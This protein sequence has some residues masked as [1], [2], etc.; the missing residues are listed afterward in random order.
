MVKSC[1]VSPKTFPKMSV[2]V[3]GGGLS[4]LSAA[5]YLLKNVPGISVTILESSNRCGGWIRSH[6]LPN[7]VIFEQGPRT[8]RPAGIP[9]A[10]T[11]QLIEDLGLTEKITPI[12]RTHP[13]ATT[14]LIYANGQLHKLPSSLLSLIKQQ[15][16]FSRPLLLHF[17]K[18]LVAERKTKTDEAIYDFIERR[19]GLEVADYLIS[20][21]ICGICAGNA[22]EI[23]VNFL[24]RS[25]FEMEQKYGSITKGLIASAFATKKADNKVSDLAQKARK[26][27]WS[28]Y[29]FQ[30]GME[31]L[32]TALQEAVIAKGGKIHYNTDCVAIKLDKQKPSVELKNG[33]TI[34]ASHIISSVPSAQLIKTDHPK[35]FELLESIQSVTV[36]VV[37][38]SFKQKLIDK[39]AFGFLV[40]PKENLPILGVIY[41][42]CCFARGGNTVLTVMM[43]GH[44]FK[45]HFGANPSK[46]KLY[47]VA[48]QQIRAILK[49][50]DEPEHFKV[51]IL[52]N[53]IPQYTVGH[54]KRVENIFGYIAKKNLRLSLCGSSYYGVGVNDVILSAKKAVEQLKI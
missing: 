35:L 46:E 2:I 43:G 38:L 27:R 48:L 7:G 49:F 45:Q 54:D 37:N 4:G 30:D 53:C 6:K 26:E 36:A 3:L 33:N 50:N 24:M 20:P 5:Y 52:Q 23:S 39:E 14:R 34:E 18:D 10:N 44:W 28:V 8:I 29:S 17:M 15:T 19:F 42:S 47:N 22:K 25:L 16:P 40:A 13:A 1:N 11:L 12:L 9:G 41:D 21:L 51:N 31:E 32:P